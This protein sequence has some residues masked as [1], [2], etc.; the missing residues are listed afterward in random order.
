M[1]GFACYSDSDYSRRARHVAIIMDGNRRYGKSLPA[2]DPLEGHWSGGRTLVD[3]VQWCMDAGVEV[4]TVYAFS[5][6]NWTRAP[7][8][9][10]T[11]MN[12]IARYAET[13]KAEALARGVQVVVLSTDRERLPTNVQ[14]SIDDLQRATAHCSSFLV[15]ICL[16]YGGRGDIVQAVQRVS[17]RVLAGELLPKQV[18][19]SLLDA[20][21]STAHCAGSSKENLGGAY[22]TVLYC[23]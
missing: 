5:T 23:S 7:G 13:F 22:C 8:E 4:L 3:C 16:S 19:E 1:T 10:S 2:G 6:E 11:L 14:R 17:Q 20:H 9:V 18:T 12:I 15:N 21:L